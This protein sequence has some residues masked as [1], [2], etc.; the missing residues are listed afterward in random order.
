MLYMKL[1]QSDL[2]NKKIAFFGGTFNPIHS[3]HLLSA[4]TV[5]EKLD[6]DLIIF[7]PANI[8][9]HKDFKYKIK[10]HRRLKMIKLAI[11][12]IK[13]FRV[14]DIELKRGGLT[15]TIDTI[16]YFFR[17]FDYPF[18]PGFIIG[19][20]LVPDLSSWRRIDELKE[21]VEFIGLYRDKHGVTT[22]EFN[23][24]WVDNRIYEISSS[25]IRERVKSGFPINFLT[26]CGVCKYI[27]N[28]GLYL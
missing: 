13:S 10:G 22:E 20:D 24:K 26:P 7:L 4:L 9:V 3:G 12:D 17:T 25:L 14:W 23:I 16:N 2:K 11:K 8:P 18:K 1:R 19:N 21:L 27:Y 15:Y 6:Y 5:L 28:R